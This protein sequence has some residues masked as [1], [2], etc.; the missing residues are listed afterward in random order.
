MVFLREEHP[1]GC[2]APNGSPESIHTGY[3]KTE[4]IVFRDIYVCTY[5]YTITINEYRDHGFEGEWVG[6]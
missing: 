3:I 5:M 2:L 6:A 4:Q 1:I